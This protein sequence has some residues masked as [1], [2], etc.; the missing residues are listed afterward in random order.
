MIVSKPHAYLHTMTKT[1]DVKFRFR[2]SALPWLPMMW[3]ELRSALLLCQFFRRCEVPLLHFRPALTAKAMKFSFRTSALP[4][5][6]K[7]WSF[8]STLLLCL[9]W[10]RSE[11]RLSKLLFCQDFE[12]FQ[13]PLPHFFDQDIQRCEGPLP[14]FISAGTS[15]MWSS[16]SALLF[17]LDCQR[18][19]VRLPR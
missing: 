10:Q 9:D 12:S 2:N 13:I 4:G 11:I 15:K 19:E 16:A 6:L 8:A 1:P 3:H 7:V 14:H 5:L 17:C 18:S